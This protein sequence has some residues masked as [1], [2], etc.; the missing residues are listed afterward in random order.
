MFKSQLVEKQTT[1]FMHTLKDEFLG[2]EYA[3]STDNGLAAMC[4]PEDLKD[5]RKKGSLISVGISA[6]AGR[7]VCVSMCM[8]ICQNG[9]GFSGSIRCGLAGIMLVTCFPV[10]TLSLVTFIDFE[11]S[12][13]PE[14]SK[15]WLTLR[16]ISESMSFARRLNRHET[17]G[18]F[19]SADA[20]HHHASAVD[21]LLYGTVHLRHRRV[22][23]VI[24]SVEGRFELTRALS[25]PPYQPDIREDPRKWSARGQ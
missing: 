7:V 25:A 18:K 20:V 2:Y 11:N 17:A 23:K 13:V 1:P 3:I 24:L 4:T 6:S 14:C 19:S 8:A 12:D 16:E 21:V 22:D 5:R 9:V 15:K 10:A